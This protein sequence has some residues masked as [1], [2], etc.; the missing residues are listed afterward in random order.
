MARLLYLL[1]GRRRLLW[2]PFHIPHHN[3][4]YH[5]PL[6][7]IHPHEKYHDSQ[8]WGTHWGWATPPR[9]WWTACGNEAP[10]DKTTTL[11]SL[12]Q[13]QMAFVNIFQTWLKLGH[14]HSIGIHRYTETWQQDTKNTRTEAF[15]TTG[16]W[17][18]PT[19]TPNRTHRH[20]QMRS[21][22]RSIVG[23]RAFENVLFSCGKDFRSLN[24]RMKGLNT[25]LS[26]LYSTDRV[27]VDH[28]IMLFMALAT[29]V[30]HYPLFD[31]D[32]WPCPSRPKGSNLQDLRFLPS[33]K[34]R[35]HPPK[36]RRNLTE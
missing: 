32:N 28:M 11:W 12:N 7:L 13:D 16:Q 8:L 25:C 5:H 4:P 27:S 29:K 21:L 23:F 19:E 22:G 3:I 6:W 31:R 10:N 9:S 35:I 14:S 1:E 36:R 34:M 20:C 33:E 24:R 15:S 2:E 26:S 30:I 18:S 17:W